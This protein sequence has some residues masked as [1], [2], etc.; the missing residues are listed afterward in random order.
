MFVIVAIRENSMR[1]RFT[2]NALGQLS[3]PDGRRDQQWFDDSLPGFGLRKFSTGRAAYFVRYQLGKQQRKIALGSYVPGILGQMRKRAADILADVR[4]GVD[5]QSQ[6]RQQAA[7]RDDSLGELIPAYLDAR[8]PELSPD[9]YSEI[10][11]FLTVYWTAFHHRPIQSLERGELVRELD[12]IAKARGAVTAD[13]CRKALSALFGWAMDRGYAT[14]NPLTR[15]KLYAKDND[16]ER[17][18]TF[19]ELIAVWKARDEDD[20]GRIVG[21]LTLT[22]QRRD[23]ISDLAWPELD[24]DHACE[25]AL[26]K[27]RTKNKRAH[28]V[29]LSDPALA[30][31]RTTSPRNERD[32]LFGEGKKGFQGWSKAKAALEIRVC[33]ILAPE[34]MAQFE[35]LAGDLTNRDNRKSADAAAHKLDFASA[36]QLLHSIMPHWTLHDL[37]RTGDTHI[38]EFSLAT[39]HV[40][41]AVL[42][43]ASGPGKRGVAKI[44]NRAKYE[45]QKRRA[46]DRWAE[47]LHKA[48]AAYERGG[49]A[50]VEAFVRQEQRKLKEPAQS[51]GRLRAAVQA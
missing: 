45:N 12:K 19:P 49:F 32:F 40:V 23:E 16:R 13:H 22:L 11:R 29:P 9:W 1:I 8:K 21:L 17:V 3:V 34:R 38:N 14:A 15:L 33:R 26:P 35:A 27:A 41:E 39:P 20:I 30:I 50:A 25:I 2:E 43:H 46:L 51:D 47:F 42:N 37:R 36:K 10:H 6:R 5:V 48:L 44:Y 18:L 28:T 7:K 24:L 31:L 4:G